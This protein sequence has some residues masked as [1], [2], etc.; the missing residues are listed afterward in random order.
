MHKADNTASYTTNP[1]Y[2]VLF[3]SFSRKPGHSKQFHNTMS[4]LQNK[5]VL[6]TGSSSGIGRGCALECAGQ[7][8]RLVLHHLG[9]PVTEEDAKALQKELSSLHSTS[10]ITYGIDLTEDTAPLKLVDAAI[11]AFGQIDVLVNNAAFFRPLPS[12][13]VTKSLV[14]T[15]VDINFVALYMVTQAVTKH[16]LQRN[17]GGSVVTISSNT[18]L[19]SNGDLAHYA[20]SKAAGLAMMQNLAV[21]YGSHGVR[22]NCVLPGPTD[23]KMVAD[24]VSDPK[25]KQV[26][27]ERCP[28]GRIATPADI[29]GAVVFFA[30][31]LSGFVTGQNIVVDGGSSFRFL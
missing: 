13:Q 15:H 24:F 30:S 12:D 22:F 28:M 3:H 11:A 23:T 19:V 27:I 17:Q 14:Q 25:T 20:G 5:V 18:V 4:L 29:A 21:E 31:D 7:G 10:S 2:H 16:M 6:I 8:A 26:M 9:S 1:L